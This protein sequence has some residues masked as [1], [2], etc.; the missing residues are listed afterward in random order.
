MTHDRLNYARFCDAP[1]SQLM[2]RMKAK[3]D[4]DNSVLVFFSDHGLRFGSFAASEV[5]DKENNLPFLYVAF[6]KWF[7][8]QF[9]ELVANVRNNARKL[10]T[11]FDLRKTLLHLLHLQ[12][13]NTAWKNDFGDG[14]QTA[15]SLMT[16]E[17]PSGR[18]CEDA[19][20]A[21]AFCSCYTL[22]DVD[23]KSEAAHHAG[24]AFVEQLNN[25]LKNVSDICVE[26]KM[27]K[28]KK[29]KKIEG[30]DKYKLHV[31]TLPVGL[32]EGWVEFKH[33]PGKSGEGKQNGGKGEHVHDTIVNVKIGEVARL[34]SYKDTSY[35]VWKRNVALKEL[36]YCRVQKAKTKKPKGK[37]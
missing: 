27:E 25:A 8:R 32:F 12:T 1:Y 21:D 11:H 19:G 29:C 13:N 17:I 9:P 34:D 16:D 6:P 7:Q 37:K 10:T 2:K 31:K 3:G 30:R 20:I 28:V 22:K 14:S 18:S 23:T 26:L 33:K 36:C 5:G 4:L 35:C 24:S 15:Y